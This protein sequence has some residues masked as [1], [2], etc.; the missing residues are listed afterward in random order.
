M[1]NKDRSTV[2]GVKT[3]F[4]NIKSYFCDEEVCLLV[5]IHII[6]YVTSFLPLYP[7][8]NL[9]IKL[10]LFTFCQPP[11][12][13]MFLWRRVVNGTR[14]KI[15]IFNLSNEKSELLY[16]YI[17]IM[18]LV[19][20]YTSIEQKYHIFYNIFDKINTYL[21]YVLFKSYLYYVS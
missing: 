14:V 10:K 17:A 6:L 8:E 21:S 19:E 12:T 11:A 18:L 9:P 16:T 20:R 2:N 1:I 4:R 13:I 15:I 7:A 5:Y 3:V